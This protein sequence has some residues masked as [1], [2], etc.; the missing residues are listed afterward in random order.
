MARAVALILLIW[1]C[2]NV[3]DWWSTT[4]FAGVSGCAYAYL[5]RSR[6]ITLG[7]SSRFFVVVAALLFGTELLLIAGY[8]Y[9]FSPLDLDG[10]IQLWQARIYAAGNLTAPAP[11]PYG[12]FF[13]Q[14][15][16]Y[17][18]GRMYSQYPPL[19]PV[20]LSLGVLVGMPWLV[21]LLI[22]GVTAYL[23]VRATAVLMGTRT[24]RVTLYLLPFSAFFL[25]IGATSLN[26]VT[27]CLGSALI[28]YGLANLHRETRVTHAGSAVPSRLTT[29][30][31]AAGLGVVASVRPLVAAALLSAVF[32]LVVSRLDFRSSLRLRLWF[33]PALCCLTIFSSYPLLNYLLHNDP[34][35]TGYE[36]LWGK[37]HHPGFHVDP[38][39][40]EHTFSRGVAIQT[41]TLDLLGRH[42][43]ESGIP[44]LVPLLLALGLVKRRSYDV[45]IVVL[46]PTILIPLLHIGYWHHDELYGPRLWYEMT[47]FILALTGW[48]IRALGLS[49]SRFV[50]KEHRS[51]WRN[52][53][54]GA[55]GGVV[56]LIATV[57]LPKR[58]FYFASTVESQR[59]PSL[60]GLLA[61]VAPTTKPGIIIL[62]QERFGSRVIALLRGAGVAGATVEQAYT[63]IP[64]CTLW[65]EV[66]RIYELPHELRAAAFT[67]AITRLP[68]VPVVRAG[69]IPGN[70]IVDRSVRLDPNGAIDADCAQQLKLDEGGVTAYAP[71]AAQDDPT[72]TGVIVAHDLGAQHNRQL[73]ELYP[74]HAVFKLVGEGELRR[75]RLTY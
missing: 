19:H 17:A 52:W 31:L 73:L 55:I 40:R 28:L 1:V 33:G 24:A 46:V 4:L 5:M 20:L 34:L 71:L 43:F 45:I 65:R 68:L 61:T 75:V 29:Y 38:W 69:D 23:T 42:F 9:A 14:N 7:C 16:I 11:G 60:Q 39:G 53:Y 66:H 18:D 3:A 10:V 50:K 59:T 54:R 21:P 72:D 27:A 58:F 57:G 32:I 2:R 51:W 37:S 8:A 67:D 30:S 47:P 74:E 63:R 12:F 26:H 70:T 6:K 35:L 15:A 44:A 13:L 22:S 41:A 49:L 56:L 64:T 36:I 48:G 62:V 25:F